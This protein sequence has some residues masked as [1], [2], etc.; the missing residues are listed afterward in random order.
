MGFLGESLVYGVWSEDGDGRYSDGGY[1]G[2]RLPVC[3]GG[4]GGCRGSVVRSVSRSGVPLFVRCVSLLGCGTLGG[5]VEPVCCNQ[6]TRP[7]RRSLGPKHA[8]AHAH[9]TSSTTS[10]AF[11]T[12]LA[13]ST[14]ESTLKLAASKIS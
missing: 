2:V 5:R 7:A 11:Q 4:K 8:H 13:T 10:D 6:T 12:I 14:D 3:R 9:H 1:R